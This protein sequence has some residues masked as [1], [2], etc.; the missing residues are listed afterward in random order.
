[1]ILQTWHTKFLGR[2]CSVE[3]LDNYTIRRTNW[4]NVTEVQLGDFITEWFGFSSD[5]NEETKILTEL[6][7][8]IPVEKM[9]AVTRKIALFYASYKNYE[10]W[11]I[12]EARPDQAFYTG[13]RIPNLNLDKRRAVRKKLTVC[14]GEAF[15]ETEG[16]KLFDYEDLQFRQEVPN[17]SGGGDYLYFENNA[18]IYGGYDNTGNGGQQTFDVE[19][20]YYWSEDLFNLLTNQRFT[21]AQAEIREILDRRIA[22]E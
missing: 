16:F 10:A 1:M 7:Q 18:I 13:P 15:K 8:K 2:P 6:L 5:K 3:L 12:P 20:V 9:N 19:S 14:L 21:K 4:V 17:D 22:E 11:D